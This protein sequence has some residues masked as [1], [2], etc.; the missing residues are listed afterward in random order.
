MKTLIFNYLKSLFAITLL[1]ISTIGVN[2]QNTNLKRYH[3]ESGEI[4]Y[5]TVSPEGK[6][7]KTVKF[8]SYGMREVTRET[9]TKNGRIIKDQLTII[10]N[11]KG[12]SIDLL[13]KTGMD[14]SERLS[15][16]MGMTKPDDGDYSEA[17]KKMLEKMGGKQV[18]SENF[19]GKNC[20]KWEINMMGKTEILLWKG[21]TLK[22]EAN[23]MGFKT[24]E[25]AQNI[26]T[27][28]SF[29]DSEFEVPDGIEIQKQDNGFSQFG[30]SD[31]ND[32]KEMNQK[33]EDLKNMSYPEFKKMM[34][35]E[36][37]NMSDEEIKQ[38][39]D[40]MKKMGDIFK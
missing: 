27:G 38:A 12:Y 8:D 33:I 23:V 25:I 35:Q 5:K 16:A 28:V 20:E 29:P 4:N 21:I 10:N 6:G 13:S 9:V 32:T 39:Y 37:P 31:D 14:I 2:A 24:S 1:F 30:Q 7:T 34:K 15:A 3:V 36:D 26:K 22:T 19:L 17:G 11:G 40:M 18:G